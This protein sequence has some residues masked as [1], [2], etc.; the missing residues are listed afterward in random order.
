MFGAINFC[1]V[2][3]PFLNNNNIIIIIIII[4]IIM[5][6]DIASMVS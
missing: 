1:F 2:M 4:I 6:V 3:E 5:I